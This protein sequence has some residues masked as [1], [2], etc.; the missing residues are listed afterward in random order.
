MTTADET[1]AIP[2]KLKA[3][4]TQALE[5]LAKGIRDPQ[6]AKHAADRM[7]RMREENCRL[8][9]EQE[10]AVGIIREMR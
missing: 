9:G 6:A 8:F 1:S 3:E 2:A 7:D 10:S 5:L 4:L